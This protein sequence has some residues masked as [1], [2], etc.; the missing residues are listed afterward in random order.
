MTYGPDDNPSYW[1]IMK[2]GTY[3]FYWFPGVTPGIYRDFYDGWHFT[4]NLWV[5]SFEWSDAW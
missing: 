3:R 2:H 4:I 1:W 5:C